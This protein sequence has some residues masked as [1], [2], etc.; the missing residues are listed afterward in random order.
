MEDK[1]MGIILYYKLHRD[2]YLKKTFC[3]VVDEDVEE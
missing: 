1:K 3:Y 2:L